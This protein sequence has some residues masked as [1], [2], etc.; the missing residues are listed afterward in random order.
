MTAGRYGD[1]IKKA[2]EPEN[3]NTGLEE[4]QN[5][6]LPENQNT[7]LPENQNTNLPENQNEPEVNLC[8]KVPKSLRQHWAAEAK[9]QGTTMTAVIMAALS[10]R[11]GK[12]D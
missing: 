2:R 11:F 6:N 12:P 4:S 1:L 7:G 5:T 10:D 8:V 3:Q 9:R